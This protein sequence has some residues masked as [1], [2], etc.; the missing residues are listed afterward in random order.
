M[1]TALRRPHTRNQPCCIST[2]REE[3]SNTRQGIEKVKRVKVDSHKNYKNVYLEN[4]KG[5]CK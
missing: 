2:A 5:V 1:R 4:Y 3:E